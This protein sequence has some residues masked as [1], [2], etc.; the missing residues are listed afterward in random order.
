MR[1]KQKV[2]QQMLHDHFNSQL[3]S[4]IRVLTPVQR[5][6]RRWKTTWPRP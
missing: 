3:L 5:K 4:P 1:R 2:M 6:V